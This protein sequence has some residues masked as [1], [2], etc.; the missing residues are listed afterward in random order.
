MDGLLI[1]SEPL[2][3]DAEIEVFADLGVRL[4]RDECTETKGRR[5]DDTVAHW[6]GRR[7]WSGPDRAEVERRL[8]A[9]VVELVRQRGQAK[10]GVGHALR[11][12]ADR[13]LDLAVATSSG[14]PVLDAVLARLGIE[15][16]FR[17]VHTAVEERAGKPDP[18]VYLTTAARLGAA[19]AH[20]VALEDSVHGVRAAKAAGMRCIAIPDL[21]SSSPMHEE[22]LG[23]ADV[24]LASLADLDEATWRRIA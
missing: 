7:P 4:T 15:A 1:D 3:Q 19:P 10:P 16:A 2:W 5:V 17:V 24:V 21:S 9:R 20:C 18:A 23:A 11:F 14:R 22:G 12:F 6:Y 13:G 8:V